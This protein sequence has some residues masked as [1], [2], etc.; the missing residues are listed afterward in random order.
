VNTVTLALLPE[1]AEKLALA[2]NDGI[3]QLR[4]AEISPTMHW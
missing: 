3:I 4:D 2:G 1:E